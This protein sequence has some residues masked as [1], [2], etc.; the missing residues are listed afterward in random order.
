[1]KK[2]FLAGLLLACIGFSATS[3][4][5]KVRPLFKTIVAAN[6]N[7]VEAKYH[8]IMENY[9]NGLKAAFAEKDDKKT[10]AM[11]SKLNDEMIAGMEKIKPELE[12]W[13]KGMSEAEKEAFGKRAESKPYLKTIFTIMFDP[14]IGK[15]IEQ[16]PELKRVLE[17]G[18]QR[19]KNLGFDEEED[20]SNYDDGD[21]N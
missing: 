18:N 4:A 5:N 12:R 15:R 16:N 11:V 21:T 2:V 6:E 19:M 3:F 8:K 20:D 1:M 9:A 13:I 7:P 10:I 14:E 17:E